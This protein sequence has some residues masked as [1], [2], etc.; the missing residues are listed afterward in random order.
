MT[1][2]QPVPQGMKPPVTAK[3]RMPVACTACP[4]HVE[5]LGHPGRGP[6]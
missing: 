4:L 2:K 1:V 5:Q 3:T 6:L